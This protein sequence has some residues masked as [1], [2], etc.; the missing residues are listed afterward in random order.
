M[1]RLFY[2]A[3]AP[4]ILLVLLGSSIAC[5]LLGGGVL[6]P[7]LRPLSAQLVQN[8]DRAFEQAGAIREDFAVDATDGVV[9]RGWKVYP[10]SA[11]GTW[12]LLFHGVSDNRM[13]MLGQAQLLLRHGYSVVM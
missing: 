2:F 11:N 7:M 6:H 12:V 8:A 1:R 5:L 10:F 3:I 4:A 9:L 13:G